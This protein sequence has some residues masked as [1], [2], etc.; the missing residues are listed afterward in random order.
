[1]KKIAII[2]C[3][4]FTTTMFA[5]DKDLL[6]EREGDVVTV[7]EFKRGDSIKLFELESGDIVLMKTTAKIDLSLLP[8]GRYVLEHCKGEKIVIEKEEEYDF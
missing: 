1:M 3:L 6:I 4:I 2:L 8:A 7:V 5:A